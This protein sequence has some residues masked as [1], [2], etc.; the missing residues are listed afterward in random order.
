MIYDYYCTNCAAKINNNSVL[1]DMQELLT[2]DSTK[3]LSILK[4]RLTE[5]EVRE[6]MN[7]GTQ[8]A[9]SRRKCTLK[10]SDLM[11]YISNGRNLND[12][13]IANLTMQDIKDY[14]EDLV[15]V[16][17]TSAGTGMGDDDDPFADFDDDDEAVEEQPVQEEQP[18][19]EKQ[20]P[21]AILA[22]EAK[23]TVVDSRELTQERLRGDLRII[24]QLFLQG[25]VFSFEL[26]LT[27]EKD[28]KGT[29]VL[30]GMVAT[31]S[32]G[33]ISMDNRVCPAC[34]AKVFPHAGTAKHQSVVFI[35]D[36]SAGKTSTLLALTHYAVNHLQ[37]D[38]GDPIWTGASTIANVEEITLLAPP[39][40]LQEELGLFTQGVAPKKTDITVRDDAY[41]ATFLISTRNGDITRRRIITLMDLPGELCEWGGELKTHE[42]LNTFPV[43]LACDTFITCFDTQTVKRAAA[44]EG[45]SNM[46]KDIN[47]NMVLR[48]PA[49]VINDT[50]QW[51][52][53]F[54]TM[55]MAHSDKR[56]YVPTMLLFTKCSELEQPTQ[57]AVSAGPTTVTPLT[58][59]YMFRQE[60]STIAGNNLYQFAC[61]QFST[62]GDLERAYHAM[63]RCSPFGY[64]APAVNMLP[65]DRA[66]W[67]DRVQRPKPHSIDN[68]MRWLLCVSG[69]INTE[70][71]Y[72]PN[73]SSSDAYRLT[74]FYIDRTQFRMENPMTAND[75]DE[76]LARCRLFENSGYFDKEF[77][78]R[79]GD[80]W[81]LGALRLESRTHPDGNAK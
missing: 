70:A 61:R 64:D 50:C 1:F 57:T 19:E 21:A 58:N 53:K 55:L 68:L 2:G 48:T 41:S 16:V 14:L 79:Y 31:R 39:A 28:D 8:V 11:N 38:L 43:A 47:G 26:Q 74:N 25:E 73:L 46:V 33:R 45:G 75:I 35:G 63:L 6:L 66:E 67:G 56:S 76:S 77:L 20:V 49:M 78:R 12:P 51:A 52:N 40:R 27:T 7:R 10:F 69:C 4:F 80:R 44:G 34:G 13:A 15:T 36:Q 59:V 9:D 17:Q 5:G 62:T 3:K 71:E 72:R 81:R 32:E 18:Q 29:D 37:F 22:L 60:H 23:D 54:Q 30:T 65:Q 42:I 24:H